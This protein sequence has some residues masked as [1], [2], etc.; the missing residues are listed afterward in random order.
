MRFLVGIRQGQFQ[1]HP[2]LRPTIPKTLEGDR[3]LV[4]TAE[5]VTRDLKLPCDIPLGSRPQTFV[6]ADSANALHTRLSW[7][8]PG[9]PGVEAPFR[10]GRVPV[11]RRTTSSGT[12]AT[13]ARVFHI[14]R[15]LWNIPRQPAAACTNGTT[16]FLP[17]ASVGRIFQKAFASAAVTGTP[18]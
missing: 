16:R 1:R 10:P 3:D 7:S 11:T 12:T 18:L 6:K 17:A 13:S 8:S 5:A 2:T 14:T 15:I 4:A 9:L